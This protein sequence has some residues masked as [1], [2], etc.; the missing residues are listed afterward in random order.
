MSRFS[1]AEVARY[2]DRHTAAFVAFGQG[3]R[4]G[5]IH[6]AVWAPGVRD[7][8]HAFHY[9]DDRIAEL[10]RGLPPTGDVP[11]V[12]DLGC[13]VG[14]SLCY[15]AERLSVRGTGITL[16]PVQAEL[17]ARRVRESGLSDRIACIQG[18][19][20]D[21]PPIAPADLAMAIESFV[22]ATA[23]ARFFVRCRDLIRPGGVLVICDDFRLS[24][25]DPG[26]A[27]VVERFCRGWHINALLDIGELQSLARASGF[28]HQST[29]DLSP[30]LEI[31]RP[32]DRAMNALLALLGWLP[33]DRTPLGP[34]LGG[35]ALQMCLDRGW[36]GYNFVVFRRVDD[37][38][39]TLPHPPPLPAPGLAEGSARANPSIR[40]SRLATPWS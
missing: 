18:D 25:S 4:T 2:Y 31:H 39:N 3:G 36:I 5:A 8:R 22:H 17:A 13:G 40:L 37:D 20:C 27:T 9:V 26:A 35:S 1:L 6:R 7:R 24:T 38:G 19:Y 15:L 10:V 32:R 21:L 12:V 33:V 30:Y 23:P 28:V 16:S 14:G 11:H 34:L 29:V